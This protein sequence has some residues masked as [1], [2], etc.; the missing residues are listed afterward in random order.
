MSPLIERCQ[1]DGSCLI[2]AERSNGE[3]VGVAVGSIKKKTLVLET[4]HVQTS[5]RRRGWGKKLMKA[6]ISWG[7]DNGAKELEGGIEYTRR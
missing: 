4:I 1:K 5:A 6:L 2:Q 3:V 7:V